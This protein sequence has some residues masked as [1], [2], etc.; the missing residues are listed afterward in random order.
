M[1]KILLI[2]SHSGKL[3]LSDKILSMEKITLIEEN[4]IVSNDDDTT[5]V[6]NTF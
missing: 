6:L 5:Q 4:E 2:T 3:F 1:K